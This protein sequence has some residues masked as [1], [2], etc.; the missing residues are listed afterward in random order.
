MTAVVMDDPPNDKGHKCDPP[1]IYL[2]LPHQ[3]PS[4]LPKAGT[5]GGMVLAVVHDEPGAVMRQ[6]VGRE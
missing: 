3:Q 1:L 5:L 4:V 2:D 6:A